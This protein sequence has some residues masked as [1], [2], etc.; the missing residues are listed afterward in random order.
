MFPGF[1]FACGFGLAHG[2]GAFAAFVAFA[3]AF[4]VAFA[5][6]VAMASDTVQFAVVA[7]PHCKASFEECKKAVRGSQWTVEFWFGPWVAGVFGQDQD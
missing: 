3:F 2:L 6:A 4:A 1:A 7:A 5:V